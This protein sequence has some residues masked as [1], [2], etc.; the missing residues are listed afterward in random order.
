MRKFFPI[1]IIIAVVLFFFKPFIVQK[2][3]PI[4]TDTIVGLYY[5]F[6]DLYAPTNPRGIP[7]HNSLIT[8][9]VRQL[10]PWRKLAIALEKKNQ[11]PLWNP[12]TF[13]GVQLSS[14]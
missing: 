2:L 12:Y 5:P 13:A 1:V 8:D 11:I 4:P 3:L 7:F 14:N 10:Y 6:R 9:P